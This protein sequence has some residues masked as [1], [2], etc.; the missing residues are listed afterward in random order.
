[1]GGNWL[2]T[3]RGP[4]APAERQNGWTLAAEAEHGGPDRIHRLLSRIDR[5]ADEVLDDV[6][7]GH[8]PDPV[9]MG[10][11]R[12]RPGFSKE[13]RTELERADV[14]RVMATTRHDTVVTRWALDHPVH[15]LFNGHVPALVVASGD[16]TGLLQAVDCPFDG[17]APLVAVLVEAWRPSAA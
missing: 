14:F 6:R 2:M 9:P 15:D 16:R 3:G 7:G 13:W 5:D 10:D 12:R 8:P 4:V 1:M 11:R 17:V